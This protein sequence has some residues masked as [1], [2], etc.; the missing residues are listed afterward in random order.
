MTKTYSPKAQEILDAAE[1]HMRSGGFDAVSFR[2][3]A[4][5]VGVKSASVHYHFPQKADL[6]EAVVSRYTEKILES[7]GEPEAT[8]IYEVRQRLDCLIG[9]YRTALYGDDKVCL[10]CMLGSEASYLPESVAAK[11]LSFFMQ[12]KG[13]T[14]TA[15]SSGA[16]SVDASAIA[17]FM[18]SSLQGA[19]TQAVATSDKSHFEIAEQTLKLWVS[20]TLK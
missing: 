1:R 17:S 12:V 10:C 4:T 19:M 9:T 16:P 18:I 3:L 5:E 13:W 7:L 2:D 20:N 15:I 14:E 11:V 6:G 8:S